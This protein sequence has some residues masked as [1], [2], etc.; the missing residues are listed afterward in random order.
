M[1][2]TDVHR[3][4]QRSAIAA[5]SS[6]ELPA[7]GLAPGVRAL[8]L[9]RYRQYGSVLFF[10]EATSGLYPFGVVGLHCENAKRW[11]L[12]RGWVKTGGGGGGLHEPFDEL[13]ANDGPRGL[14]RLGSSSDP[15]VRLTMGWVSSDAGAIQLTNRQAT[16]LQPV[17]VDGFV[18][19]GTTAD[20]PATHATAV[21]HAH[22]PLGRS[23]VL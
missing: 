20:Q 13:V 7:R 17:G 9:W 14:R 3:V 11:P 22:R 23:I 10:A 1:T 16:W 8:D 18:L 5:L 6:G 2:E 4:V 19:L 15:A 12:I 21:D